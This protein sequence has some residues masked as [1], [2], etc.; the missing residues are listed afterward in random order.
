M[1]KPVVRAIDA[2]MGTGKSTWAINEINNTED[3][4]MIVV[5][6][7]KSEIERYVSELDSESLTVVGLFEDQEGE[8]KTARFI[9]ALKYADCIV[10]THKLFEDHISRE[11]LQLIKDGQW[12]LTIDETITVF[13]HQGHV[14]SIDIKGFTDDGI[15]TIREINEG[16]S[17]LEL[18]PSK[19]DKY[20]EWDRTPV[21]RKIIKR[22]RTRDFLIIKSKKGKERGF[23]SFSMSPVWFEAFN[24]VTLMT[25]LFKGSDMSYWLNIQGFTVEHLELIRDGDGHR[26]VNHSGQ[27]SGQQFKDLITL[28]HPQGR[29]K[30]YGNGK[31]DLSSTSMRNLR[32]DGIPM[33][34][35]KNQLRGFISRHEIQPE[36]FMFTVKKENNNKFI[37]RG[38]KLHASY[39]GLQNWEATTA[40]GT[41]KWENKTAIYYCT[42]IFQFPAV[43]SIIE[44]HGYDYEMTH[45]SLST[46]VQFIWRS[47][48]RKGEKIILFI[49]SKRMRLLFEEWLNSPVV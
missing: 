26:L 17:K 14:D 6:P 20:M 48:I 33:V 30:H 1:I 42:N 16:V 27:Y 32:V 3:K 28:D 22:L 40:R 24:D 31:N 39:V 36:D 49:Q 25:Y 12:S 38:R 46:M 21:K 5:L 47:A 23:Y 34:Q 18:V 41:N 43:A 37:D 29:G 7:Y 2:V 35:M 9:E 44:E 10:I 4:R 8:T 13:E 19:F 15:V 11:V 45:Y